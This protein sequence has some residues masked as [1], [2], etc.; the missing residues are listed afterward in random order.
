VKIRGDDP[1]AKILEFV[2]EA[3]VSLRDLGP[4]LRKDVHTDGE[5][6]AMVVQ[7]GSDDRDSC[8]W[9]WRVGG[10]R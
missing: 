4:P 8:G 6:N 1:L 3:D 10:S 7:L 5:I 9:L 2:A